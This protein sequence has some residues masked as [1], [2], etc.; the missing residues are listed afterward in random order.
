[1]KAIMTIP[2]HEKP[3][4]LAEDS[5]RTTEFERGYVH[6]EQSRQLNA[7]P[8]KYLMFGI[9]DYALGFRA[10]YFANVRTAPSAGSVG[11]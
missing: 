10:G 3:E 8:P 2:T 5:S 4:V 11:R 1:M 9:D 6:G 7:L